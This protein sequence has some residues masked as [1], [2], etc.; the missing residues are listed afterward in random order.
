MTLSCIGAETAKLTYQGYSADQ[1]RFYKTTE[2]PWNVDELTLTKTVT[3]PD[4]SKPMTW[5]WWEDEW[6][7]RWKLTGTWTAGG[8][9]NCGEQ[10]EWESSMTNKW[11][12]VYFQNEDGKSIGFYIPPENPNFTSGDPN[13]FFVPIYRAGQYTLAKVPDCTQQH[14]IPLAKAATLDAVSPYPGG[15]GKWAIRFY[16]NGE[17][18]YSHTIW[19]YMESPPTHVI[20]EIKDLKNI[21][22]EKELIKDPNDAF[23]LIQTSVEDESWILNK[24]LLDENQNVIGQSLIHAFQG[25]DAQ[26]FCLEPGKC[27]ENSCE[28]DCGD[29]DC[30]YNQNGYA[31]HSYKKN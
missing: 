21:A 8:L 22:V 3:N 5:D 12:D 29:H 14:F 31:I 4:Q 27:P 15:N 11:A 9:H 24:V 2:K 7:R 1:V 10:F 30:C 20:I 19:G 26:L 6:S 23:E 13:G 18:F 28:V 16:H 25:K 17:H